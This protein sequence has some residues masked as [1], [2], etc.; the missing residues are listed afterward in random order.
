MRAIVIPWMRG[1]RSKKAPI[2]TRERVRWAAEQVLK[3]VRDVPIYIA[4]PHVEEEE[5]LSPFRVIDC[6]Q[7]VERSK[8]T[9]CGIMTA[10]WHPDLDHVNI[11]GVTA[12]TLVLR[13]PR[14]VMLGSWYAPRAHKKKGRR[15]YGDWF[16]HYPAGH[17]IRPICRKFFLEHPEKQF[18]IDK[19][20]WHCAEE[21]GLQPMIM[22]PPITVC[23]DLAIKKRSLPPGPSTAAIHPT[24]V[25]KWPELADQHYRWL[26]SRFREPVPT[27]DWP[28]L[29]IPRSL[30]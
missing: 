29:D 28:D 19:H 24:T 12:D 25:R 7:F 26:R 3:V 1:H 6:S 18:D 20:I 27:P 15:P 2:Y 13:D 11:D 14:D 9:Q 17:P 23:A 22:E 10:W 21:A 4:T 8:A 5:Y 16:C 30:K